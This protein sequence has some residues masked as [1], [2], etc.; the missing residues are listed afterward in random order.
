MLLKRRASEES[1]MFGDRV[2]D[3]TANEVAEATLH[4]VE[5]IR[6]SQSA[7]NVVELTKAIS[8]ATKG[9]IKQA[10]REELLQDT[11]AQILELDLIVF[12]RRVVPDVLH[13]IRTSSFVSA[14]R[15][16]KV[17]KQFKELVGNLDRVFS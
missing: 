16:D 9:N 10:K 3:F 12:R 8:E 15:K 14:S 5:T 17:A 1:P 13:T 7:A 4:A 2:S 11:A 6:W